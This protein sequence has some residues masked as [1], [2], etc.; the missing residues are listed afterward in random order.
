KTFTLIAAAIVGLTLVPV[1]AHLFIGGG[2]R[3]SRPHVGRALKWI[4]ALGIASLLAWTT[5][6]FGGWLEARIGLRAW[7]M[8]GVVFVLAAA[9]VLRMA[10]EQLTPIES[11]PVA[12]AIVRTYVPAL[13]FFLRRKA[14][15]AGLYVFFLF[16]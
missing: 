6:R 12:R 2:A 5:L 3:A 16:L 4:A 1:L 13:T 7:F 11:N 8:A 14:V 9:A 10:R 15:L